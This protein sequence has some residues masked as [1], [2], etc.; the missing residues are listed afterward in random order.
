MICGQRLRRGDCIILWHSMLFHFMR[1]T[2]IVMLRN[3]ASLHN[4]VVAIKSAD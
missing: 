3:E 2:V 1:P 4:K